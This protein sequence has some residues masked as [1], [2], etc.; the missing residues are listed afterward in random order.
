M[1]VRFPAREQI[2]FFL[3]N[4][5]SVSWTHPSPYLT[6]QSL[7]VIIHEYTSRFS[8]KNS[9]FYPHNLVMYCT[10][11]LNKWPSFCTHHHRMV[12]QWKGAVKKKKKNFYIQ[13]RPPHLVSRTE[14]KNTWHY[15]FI[16]PIHFNGMLFMPRAN[17]FSF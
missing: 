4:D 13:Y 14:L 2:Y 12:F 17:I 5:E 11:F 3:Q 1:W 7:A 15:T 16:A 10:W 6:L 9:A 8:H